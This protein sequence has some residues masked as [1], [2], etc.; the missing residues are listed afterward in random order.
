MASFCPKYH[1]EIQSNSTDFTE[2][3]LDSSNSELRLFAALTPSALGATG[4]STSYRGSPDHPTFTISST[5]QLQQ[6]QIPH[7]IPPNNAITSK[8]RVQT[9]KFWPLHFNAC[10]MTKAS[11]ILML[12]K[13][14]DA[15]MTDGQKPF[16]FEKQHPHPSRTCCVPCIALKLTAYPALQMLKKRATERDPE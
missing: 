5:E 8:R 6:A 1:P 9:Q 7:A 13:L 3:Y 2:L 16:W 4:C 10:R 14:S 12:G 11:T 15:H